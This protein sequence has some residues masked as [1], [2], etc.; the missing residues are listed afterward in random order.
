MF[1][2]HLKNNKITRYSM[3]FSELVVRNDIFIYC[4]V[5][6]AVAYSRRSLVGKIRY[7]SVL[8]SYGMV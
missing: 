3:A 5:V 8:C 6:Y 2:S 1:L 4:E 7:G